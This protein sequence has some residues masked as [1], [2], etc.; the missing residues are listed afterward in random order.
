MTLSSFDH[1]VTAV[2]IGA[3]GGIGAAFVR[4]LAVDP[5]LAQV[6]ALSRGDVPAQANVT[7]H[8]ADIL[9]EASLKTAA[10]AIGEADLVLVATGV[11]HGETAAG[12]A[13]E[14]EKSFKQI[15]PAPM[16][17]VL[18][19]NTVGPALAAKHFLPLLPR[20]RRAVFAALS[21]R[22]GSIADNRLGG[23]HSYRASKAALNQL[24]TCFAIELGRTKKQAV[25]VGLHP[26]TV[27]TGLS[28]PFQKGVA[29]QK[30]F[31]PD[32]SAGRLLGVIDGLTPQASGACFD[33]AGEQV[34]A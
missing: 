31:S 18:A 32:Q 19:V 26:G 1:P 6:H 24:V 25:I 9:D 7:A 11:L 8:R 13:F 12:E 29:P 23:W 27:D 3:G 5:A 30:L 33:W 10:A 4:A 21:A 20:S 22:V 14:P 16:E 2:V 28:A 15:A 17:R 34:P